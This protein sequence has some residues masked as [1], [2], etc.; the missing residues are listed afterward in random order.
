MHNIIIIIIIIIPLAATNAAMVATTVSATVAACIR[1]VIRGGGMINVRRIR[2]G[3]IKPI[4]DG[5]QHCRL[6]PSRYIRLMKKEARN[7][8]RGVVTN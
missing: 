1:R 8:T 7:A 5:R 2:R 4:G 6:R 3:V